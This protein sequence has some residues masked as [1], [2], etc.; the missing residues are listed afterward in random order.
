MEAK[1]VKIEL[2]ILYGDLGKEYWKDYN[3]LER[4]FE[5][6]VGAGDV[7]SG[8]GYLERKSRVNIVALS[9]G[10]PA[11]IIRLDL[12]NQ[13]PRIGWLYVEPEFRNKVAAVVNTPWLKS[14]EEYKVRQ[15]LVKAAWITGR[16]AGFEEI[17]S[18]IHEEAGQKSR[19]WRLT[20]MPKWEREVVELHEPRELLELIRRKQELVKR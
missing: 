9:E 6:S 10:K 13:P 19:E 11:G 7:I 3:P 14:E 8:R 12:L 16:R 1:P 15:H 20:Q 18:V 5:E 17:G 2:K 4:K